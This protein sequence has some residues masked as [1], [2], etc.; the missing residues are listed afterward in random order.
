MRH[1]KTN[2]YGHYFTHRHRNINQLIS[3]PGQGISSNIINASW[4]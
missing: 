1:M 2:H 4:V 3:Y